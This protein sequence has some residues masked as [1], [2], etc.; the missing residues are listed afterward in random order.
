[1]AA[2]FFSVNEAYASNSAVFGF[3]SIA[4]FTDIFPRGLLDDLVFE[5]L[6]DFLEL[7]PDDFFD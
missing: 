4:L 5:E 7:L 6:D 1:M 2:W 3:S